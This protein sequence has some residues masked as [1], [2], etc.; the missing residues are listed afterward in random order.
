MLVSWLFAGVD[1][2]RV[3]V[4]I[5]FY[6]AE[7]TLADA[8]R[9]VFAQTF[10]DWELILVDDGSSDASAEI[11]QAVEDPRVRILSDGVNR[12][13]V[14]RLNQIGQL[15]RGRYLARMDADDLMHPE[16]LSRQVEYLDANPKVDLVGTGAYTIDAHNHLTG[17][18]EAGPAVISP[19]TAL[20]RCLFIHPTVTG[21]PEWFRANPYDE[22]F[23]RAEDH[24]LWCRTCRHTD[25]ARLGDLLFFYR[26]SSQ[27]DVQPYLK[28]HRTN[29]KTI[30]RYGPSV[31]GWPKTSCLIL[32]SYL[33]SGIFWTCAALGIQGIIVS[34][35]DSPLSKAQRVEGAEALN[36]VLRTPVPGLSAATVA[37]R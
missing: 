4:G 18:R 35:R 16:R 36:T 26:D 17:K 25:S 24:E 33:K 19:E 12:G 22:L 23:V 9:S 5:P 32:E 10:Q 2:M 31:V 21:R 13:L 29:R 11:A 34:R 37:T 27:L 8:I 20:R 14:Y 28:S 30:A 7:Q 1:Q 15:A 3:S 6:N